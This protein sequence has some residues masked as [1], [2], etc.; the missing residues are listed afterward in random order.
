[1]ETA[2]D[3]DLSP[4]KDALSNILWKASFTQRSWIGL[5]SST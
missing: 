2:P 4:S 3:V 5:L 1:M